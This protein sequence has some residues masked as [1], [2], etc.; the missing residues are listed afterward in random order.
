MCHTY[1]TDHRRSDCQQRC[2]SLLIRWVMVQPGVA[3]W[4]L[5]V[6]HGLEHV[7]PRLEEVVALSKAKSPCLSGG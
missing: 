4:P 6:S 7:R 5:H 2:I 1:V 3:K